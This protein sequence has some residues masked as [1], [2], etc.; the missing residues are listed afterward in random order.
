MV[1]LTFITL[2]ALFFV[3]IPALGKFVGFVSDLGKSNKPISSN[4]KTPPPP[5]KFKTF[6][7]FTN[8]NNVT[9]TGNTEAGSTVK[10]T[11][12]GNE[13]STLSDKDGNFTFSNIQLS[14]GENQF[15]AVSVDSAGNVS[16]KTPDYK[17]TFDTKPPELTIS[18]PQEGSS[19]FGS[20]QRQVTIQGTTESGTQITINGRIV[21]VDDTGK[22]QYSVSLTDGDNKFTIK[23]TDK[24]GNTT[25]K[26]LALSFTP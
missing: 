10:L 16:Q 5:P 23:A 18:S 26:E 20:S 2:V 13:Q 14:D 8:Q 12:D 15:S 25:E 24:A 3:G 17:I 7:E 21:A 11:F 1:F 9:L 22:F 4:D 19:Y 6:N